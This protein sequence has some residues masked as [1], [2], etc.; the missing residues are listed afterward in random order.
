MQ[1]RHYGPLIPPGCVLLILVGAAIGMSACS[2]RS[3]QPT[4]EGQTSDA[5]D[6]QARQAVQF[7]FRFFP[8]FWGSPP[9][10]DGPLMK[11]TWTV[12]GASNC[13][14]SHNCRTVQYVVKNPVDG[15]AM[16]C[17]W[18]YDLT[19]Q[20]VTQ[21]GDDAG[22]LFF[23]L[24]PETIQAETD[25]IRIVK[26]TQIIKPSAVEALPAFNHGQ[27]TAFP[28]AASARG[29]HLY[30]VYYVVDVDASHS[31]WCHWLINR[32]KSLITPDANAARYFANESP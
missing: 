4:A 15:S 17:E 11:G 24:T 22:K 32:D 9:D 30:H 1:A 19:E 6:D 16:R 5:T 7:G 18:V 2:E 23:Q 14:P 10:R 13:P 20:R 21:T 26:G 29:E 3:V 12:V 8:E 25:A 31:I 27:W 28:G